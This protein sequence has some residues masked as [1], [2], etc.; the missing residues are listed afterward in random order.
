MIAPPSFTS[1]EAHVSTLAN[2]DFWR[3]YVTAVLE[4]QG[5]A[6]AGRELEAGFNATYP[7]FLYGDV[8]VKL[9]GYSRVWRKSH[10][11]ER[12]A[13]IL[14]ASDPE[15]AAPRLLG[16]GRLYEGADESW[17]YL[18]TTRLHAEARWRVELT[19]VQERA[20][21]SE[22]GRQVRRVH[23]LPPE[24]VATHADWKAVDVAAAAKQSS[25]PAHL[26]A[27]VPEYVA[28]LGPADEVFV[29]GDITANHVYVSDGRLSGV[30]D[31]GDAMVTDR[32]YELIQIYRDMLHC[33]KA[34]FRVF[35]DACEWPVA[36]D[37]P[38]RVLGHALHRQAVGLAQHH[39]MDVFEPI[40]ARLPLNA[41][42][43]LDELAAELFEV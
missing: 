30:I 19:G 9:F 29:H 17:P 36:G 32:H 18:V 40:A 33:D 1:L 23:A 35:L 4:R 13:H 38:R 8:V 10:A 20:L 15:I 43:N 7:T 26:V 27:Q 2:V 12:G 39:S 11:A 37:F 28:G 41:I 42:G 31:W 5:L 22:L 24:N 3:P 25:L 16:E 14:I 34:L 21:A 6:G